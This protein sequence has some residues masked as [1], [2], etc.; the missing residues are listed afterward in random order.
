MIKIFLTALIL[1]S[2]GFGGGPLVHLSGRSFPVRSVVTDNS[3][4]PT[5]N[6]TYLTAGMNGL[7]VWT[8]EQA[9]AEPYF[10]L[11]VSQNGGVATKVRLFRWM[12]RVISGASGDR[13]SLG[14]TNGRTLS[15]TPMY[16]P[17]TVE[18]VSGVTGTANCDKAGPPIWAPAGAHVTLPNNARA[19]KINS[20]GTDRDVFLSEFDGS[21][22]T[23]HRWFKLE[24]NRATT[25]RTSYGK[26]ALANYAGATLS[27]TAP[28]GSI[29][30][31]TQVEMSL[32]FPPIT[33]T[34]HNVATV[35]ALK[36]AIAAAVA[37]D[38]IVLAAGTYALDVAI[39]QTNFVANHGVGPKKGMDGITIRGATGTAADVILTGDGTST[40]GNW[41]LNHDG[42][43]ATNHACFKDLTFN[44]AGIDAGFD[45]ST[46]NWRIQNIRITGASS[47]GRDS[48]TISSQA[49]RA[50]ILDVLRTQVDNSS[51]DCF[52]GGGATHA[53]T[54]I[55]LIECIGFTASNVSS[56]Q[57]ITTHTGV[58]MEVYSGSFSDSNLNVI[59][60]DGATSSIYCFFIRID[61]GARSSGVNNASLFGSTLIMSASTLTPHSGEYIIATTVTVTNYAG[62][63]SLLRSL[64]NIFV[65]HNRF[66]GNDGRCWFTSLSNSVF[67]FNIVSGFAEGVRV[68]NSSGA[69]GLNTVIGNT[70]KSCTTA[71]AL[72]DAT[73]SVLMN[74]NACLTNTLSITCTVTSDPNINGNYNV[75]DPT[76]DTDYTAGANDTSGSN[77]A[78]DA[79]W[80]PTASGNCDGNGDT[81]VIDW[82]GGSDPFGLLLVYKATRVSRG[83]REIPA[84]YSASYFRPDLW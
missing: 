22:W 65:G 59:A 67:N 63:T 12:G 70:F 36:T 9:T 50:M 34:T 38:D 7:R 76:V 73:L 68:D 29:I 37:G 44:F 2:C 14:T 35:A 8:G 54:K 24:A 16:A 47:S 79:N 11:Y 33:G 66:I 43:S 55:R 53:S 46:G 28:P 1:I 4:T 74:G 82:V 15:V 26:I 13:F 18:T 57:I 39:S 6:V 71:L 30:G 41:S 51:Q 27:V 75:L 58:P 62:A 5:T 69:T 25:I 77:A 19:F 49:T 80:F 17:A 84:I 81:S 72:S 61:P 31:G 10:D 83:A 42:G 52:N 45:I 40:H 20:D 78:I 48:F 3:T 32:V 64:T 23:P 60:T 56:S 21:T